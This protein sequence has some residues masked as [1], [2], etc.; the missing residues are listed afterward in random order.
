[1]AAQA[2]AATGIGIETVIGIVTAIGIET[3]IEIT[4]VTMIEDCIAGGTNT[5][6]VTMMTGNGIMPGV[7]TEITTAKIMTTTTAVTATMAKIGTMIDN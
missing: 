5:I 6:A 2:A 3:M 7:A 1:M 4:I